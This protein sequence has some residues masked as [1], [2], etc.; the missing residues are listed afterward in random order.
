MSRRT[1]CAD[2][3]RTILSIAMAATLAAQPTLAVAG[4][5]VETQGPS[6]DVAADVLT[7]G[8]EDDAVAGPQEA[9]PGVPPGGDG[10]PAPE[11]PPD[12]PAGPE[13]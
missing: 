10:G 9:G 2:P 5:A 12:G 11:E 3:K 7:V 4:T 8:V 1:R 6:A 13:W